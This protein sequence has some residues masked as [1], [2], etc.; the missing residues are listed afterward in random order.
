M[1]HK[2][3]IGTRCHGILVSSDKEDSFGQVEFDE[4]GAIISRVEVADAFGFAMTNVGE[5]PSSFTF[6]DTSGFIRFTELARTGTLS[7]TNRVVIDKFR[8]RRVIRSGNMECDYQEIDGMCTVID[9]LAAWV[10][11]SAVETSPLFDKESEEI[12]GVGLNARNKPQL[13]IGGNFNLTAETS[14]S[15]PP[16]RE[17]NRFSI[18]DE[19]LLRTHS[20]DLA[21][22]GDHAAVHR[23]MQDLLC[24]VYGKPVGMR[25][26]S[27]KR[28]DD[29]EGPVDEES[30]RRWWRD[31]YEPHLGRSATAPAAS[32]PE[33][34]SPMFLF[35]DVDLGK[36]QKWL[37]EFSHWS[38]PT[39]IAVSSMFQ[40]GSVVEVELLQMGVA[41]E[42]LG[43]AIWKMELEGLGNSDERTPQYPQL[44]NRVTDVALPPQFELRQGMSISNWRIEF[45]RAFK[46]AKHADNAA[47][48]PAEA[49]RFSGEAM[50]LIRYWIAHQIGVPFDKI[51]I[52]SRF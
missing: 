19:V 1:K 27:I 22:W 13:N 47:V 14:F 18:T 37:D 21:P 40:E 16:R 44:L 42:A 10:G 6:A 4:G 29:Q 25:L 7:N 15:H 33:D 11:L 24:L 5:T 31:A 26:K 50:D 3:E 8:S 9:G 12:I 45:N 35:E 48:D 32:L 20:Q 41:L 30:P 43:Y 49:A 51:N 38:R 39:W 2:L 28:E 17:G 34:S 23:M 46:G 52:S 36:M